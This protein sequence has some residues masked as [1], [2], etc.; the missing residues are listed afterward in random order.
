[1][2]AVTLAYL[3][4]RGVTRLTASSTG[5]SSTAL[6]DVIRRHPEMHL[7][8]FTRSL[9]P[10]SRAC[11]SRPSDSCRA[12]RADVRRGGRKAAIYARRHGLTSEA[13]FFNPDARGLKLA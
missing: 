7:F 3:N 12:T 4:E 6:A 10:P 5:N 9:S 2:A 13:G 11:R 1:M 8:L